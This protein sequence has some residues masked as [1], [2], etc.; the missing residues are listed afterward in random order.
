MKEVEQMTLSEY[1][2]RMLAFRLSEVDKA[3]SQATQ[4]IMI[5]AASGVDSNG[6]YV[7]KEVKDLFDYDEAIKEIY[8]PNF[9]VKEMNQELV[10]RAKRLQQYN[11]RKGDE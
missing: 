6:E 3:K 11:A 1:S 5:N 4:A 8:N 10:R 2:I 9:D 7:I